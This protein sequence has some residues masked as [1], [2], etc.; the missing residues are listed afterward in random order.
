[1]SEELLPWSPENLLREV[2]EREVRASL[3][4]L[5]CFPER[6][7][8][9]LESEWGTFIHSFAVQLRVL[10]V[11]PLLELIALP[12]RSFHGSVDGAHLFIVFDND[13]ERNIV[14]ALASG[15]FQGESVLVDYLSRRFFTSIVSSWSGP[16]PKQARFFGETHP[17]FVNEKLQEGG[18]VVR[19]ELLINERPVGVSVVLDNT[20]FKQLDG[21]WRRQLRSTTNLEKGS[22]NVK[23]EVAQLAVQP[24]LLADYTRSETSIDLEVPVTD[25]VTLKVGD[26][27]WLIARMLRC[28][29]R[30]VFESVSA[31]ILP[32]ELP[33][34]TTRV[35]VELPMISITD[36][37]LVEF[38]Q[39]GA[40]L[41]TEVP[42]E[43]MVT[44]SIN[45]EQVASAELGIY[46]GRLAVSIL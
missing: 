12:G 40:M 14:S 38:G 35:T 13:A 11:R 32:R 3:G 26:K 17:D 43:N 21:I 36:H 10:K 29:N 7:V 22:Y 24:A 42:L 19:I 18:G 30:L 41:L 31:Q 2:G 1:M 23:I 9:G 6:W 25:L 34:G 15:M 27:P 46:E 39:I 4:F 16:T 45:S 28:E 5:R 33:P 8:P 37:D 20:L 44:L